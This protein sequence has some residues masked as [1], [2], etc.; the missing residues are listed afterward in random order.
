MNVVVLRG[1][2]SRDAEARTLA[3]GTELVNYEVTVRAS[4]QAAE[5]VPVVC[6]DP[7]LATRALTAGTEV[8]VS[9]R[10]RRRFFRAGGVTASR[11]E[12]VAEAIL[13]ARRKAQVAR[14]VDAA[15][16]ALDAEAPI[17]AAAST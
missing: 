6:V 12:V 13:P 1:T 2:L 9:G 17:E 14:L 11:T 15:I 3:S 5:T 16:A 8:V 7:S 10:V 4:G